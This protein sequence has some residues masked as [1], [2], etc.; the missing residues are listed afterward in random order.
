VNP[1]RSIVPEPGRRFLDTL[2]WMA[3]ITIRKEGERGWLVQV[4]DGDTRSEHSVTIP[5][6]YLE[7]LGIESEP[8]RAIEESFRFLLEREPM[9]QIL[10]AFDLPMIESY[11]PEYPDQM[12]A[13]FS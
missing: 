10:A 13:R 6:G 9:E 4:A 11:F 5:E 1:F 8:E 12:R 7:S 2:A 3:D